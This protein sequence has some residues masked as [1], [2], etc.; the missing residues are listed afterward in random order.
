MQIKAPIAYSFFESM[1]KIRKTITFLS[2]KENQEKSNFWE[3][4][5]SE[6]CYRGKNCPVK[7]DPSPKFMALILIYGKILGWPPGAKIG[8]I[9]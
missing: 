5:K 1:N 8:M 6:F 2:L 3:L 9:L 4:W 7:K